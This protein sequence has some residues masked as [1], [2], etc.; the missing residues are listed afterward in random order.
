MTGVGRKASEDKMWVLDEII[1]RQNIRKRL[2]IGL[3]LVMVLC[4]LPNSLM[5]VRA[6][7]EKI[8]IMVTDDSGN[9]V[10]GAF[11]NC[12]KPLT[13]PQVPKTISR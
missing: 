10:E 4:L 3:T 12:T 6:E 2:A 5:Q 9:A 7:K 1:K 11:V 13:R 8:F